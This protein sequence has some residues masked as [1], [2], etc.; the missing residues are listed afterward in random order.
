MGQGTWRP[1]QPHVPERCPQPRGASGAGGG[2]GETGG[3]HARL[4]LPPCSLASTR[5][6]W[7][8]RRPGSPALGPQDGSGG[9][10]GG[11]RHARKWRGWRGACGAAPR[12]KS[13]G[14]QG[15]PPHGGGVLG[16]LPSG[17]RQLAGEGAVDPSFISTSCSHTLPASTGPEPRGYELGVPD[18]LLSRKGTPTP[19]SWGFTCKPRR[20]YPSRSCPLP[21]CPSLGLQPCPPLQTAASSPPGLGCRPSHMASPLPWRDSAKVSPR[22]R[23]WGP[24]RREAQGCHP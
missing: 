22:P 6:M 5:L 1:P 20:P 19:S 3:P 10:S 12:A 17:L 7:R 13:Q 18:W 21:R 9:R 2:V 11:P 23:V 8:T 24:G 15:R 4:R 14:A 16:P